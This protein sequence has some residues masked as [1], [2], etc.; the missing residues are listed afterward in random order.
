H[1]LS[2]SH[3]SSLYQPSNTK[4]N[5]G[6]R[7]TKNTN[8]VSIYK[9]LFGLGF[10]L[11]MGMKKGGRF[12][13][14]LESIDFDFVALDLVVGKAFVSWLSSLWCCWWCRFGWLLLGL[15]WLTMTMGLEV[16]DTC[17]V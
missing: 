6:N 15:F 1:N 17:Y 13:D 3:L 2:I 11:N 4:R 8:S 9:D 7:E 10:P 16:V 12:G 5:G 14:D